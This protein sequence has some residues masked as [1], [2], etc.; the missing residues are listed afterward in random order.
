MNWLDVMTKSLVS[1]L[2]IALAITGDKASAIEYV[3]AHSTAG[4][5]AWESAIAQFA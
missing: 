5:K 2:N 4:A 1:Q 3:K